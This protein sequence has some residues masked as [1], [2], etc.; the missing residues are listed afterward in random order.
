MRTAAPA[1]RASAVPTPCQCQAPEGL[2]SNR[3]PGG[4]RGRGCTDDGRTER[5][6]D[7]A[8]TE[9]PVRRSARSGRGAASDSGAARA[10][11]GLASA[12][13]R[14]GLRGMRAGQGRQSPHRRLEIKSDAVATPRPRTGPRPGRSVSVSRG[15]VR[16]TRSAWFLTQGSGSNTGVS[17]P[18]SDPEQSGAMTSLRLA[19][20]GVETGPSQCRGRPARGGPYSGPPGVFH[21]KNVCQR[22]V[23]VLPGRPTSVAD[24][25]LGRTLGGPPRVEFLE[26]VIPCITILAPLRQDTASP[27]AITQCPVTSG[28]DR[29]PHCLLGASVGGV[30]VVGVWGVLGKGSGPRGPLRPR[31]AEGAGREARMHRLLT[32]RAAA[33]AV[34]RRVRRPPG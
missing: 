15:A 9:M 33:P 32:L 19:G 17:G 22:H 21:N 7:T 27:R 4:P 2:E 31:W 29:A 20:P 16:A 14:P 8:S 23:A 26:F 18:R 5:R 11:F 6:T 28:Q 1:G 24:K 34:P 30:D 25:V 12:P 3:S 13:P 10:S